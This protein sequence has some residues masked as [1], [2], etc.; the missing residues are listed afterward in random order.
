[1]GAHVVGFAGKEV[2]RL[3][4]K[5]VEW[6][7]GLDPAGPLFEIPPQSKANRLSNDDARWVEIIHSDGGILGFISPIGDNDFYPN[8]GRF[9]QPS[10]NTNL[11][12]ASEFINSNIG[13]AII[14]LLLVGCSHM[15]SAIFYTDAVRKGGVTAT[16]CISWEIYQSGQC[17]GNQRATYGAE[18]PT[19]VKGNFYNV[20]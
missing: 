1:M 13:L 4:G 7:T 15:L 10:C 19:K 9:I 8:G 18:K 2:L 6:I 17:N 14:G 20:V 11:A 3:T 12:D 16:K 5:K